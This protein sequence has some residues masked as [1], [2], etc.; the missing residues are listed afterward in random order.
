LALIVGSIGTPRVSSALSI[1]A[2]RSG[3]YFDNN[4]FYGFVTTSAEALQQVRYALGLLE[5]PS[6]IAPFVSVKNE[7]SA[8]LSFE[9]PHDL[10]IVEV[11]ARRNI[12]FDGFHL[13]LR[14]LTYYFQ[15]RPRLADAIARFWGGDAARHRSAFL[16]REPAFESADEYEKRL[17]TRAT[18][19]ILT[20]DEIVLDLRRLHALVGNRLVITTPILDDSAP[21]S[22][23]SHNSEIIAVLESAAGQLGVPVLNPS[24]AFE[25]FVHEH[26]R[27]ESKEDERH[28]W[29]AFDGYLA[30]VIRRQFLE[31]VSRMKASLPTPSPSSPQSAAP[32][33]V[34][35][36][37]LSRRY[38]SQMSAVA[39][40]REHAGSA[41]MLVH[42]IGS[43]A[44]EGN[45]Q[46]VLDSARDAP[47]LI[48][49][50]P[51][52]L[53]SAAA[54]AWYL[55]DKDTA[56]D[57]WHRRLEHGTVNAHRLAEAVELALQCQD[58]ESVS[59]WSRAAVAQEPQ[60]ASVLL[61]VLAVYDQRDA[62]LDVIDVLI[63]QG[64]NVLAAVD[65]LPTELKQAAVDRAA[66]RGA[67][68]FDHPGGAAILRQWLAE[69]AAHQ[70]EGRLDAVREG[71]SRFEILGPSHPAYQSAQQSLLRA[72][73]ARSRSIESEASP[74]EAEALLQE[75]RR[76]DPLNATAILWLA[77][78][79]VRRGDS[80][81]AAQLVEELACI[82]QQ[83]QP[84]IAAINHWLAASDAGA[85][86][87]A[88][89]RA[90]RVLGDAETLALPRQR[91]CTFLEREIEKRQR[92]GDLDVVEDLK[93]YHREL[94]RHDGGEREASGRS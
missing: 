68:D 60:S 62:I 71:V 79:W 47:E 19:A 21:E 51:Q 80:V 26:A 3:S 2:G 75:A 84:Q 17:L 32:R 6:E 83:P 78:L 63:S 11:A 65:P 74:E 53:E 42:A 94:C 18:G 8:E 37:W 86:A 93:R 87:R 50:D 15:D 29:A 82:D 28:W 38:S 89:Q 91:T 70:S 81:Q 39:A 72:L 76:V 40:Q 7:L 67:V 25:A 46:Y 64:S 48:L 22:L 34:L 49:K 24:A 59:N 88:L 73:L 33:G 52:L 36:R 41:E 66:A 45:W 57:L 35:T 44:W 1:A 77:R 90:L 13:N 54:A 31:P 30:D 85:A 20:D 14:A 16:A 27:S 23:K 58:A 9:L 4:P 43:A 92:A 61:R 55:G 69:L 10:L 56:L 5:I 12:S